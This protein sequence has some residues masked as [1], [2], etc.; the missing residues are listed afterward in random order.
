MAD[1]NQGG[2]QVKMTKK[3]KK[4]LLKI[5]EETAKNVMEKQG[6]HMP[7]IIF[8]T[9]EGTLEFMLLNIP[10]E[11]IKHMVLKGLRKKVQIEKIP[12]YFVIME[13][14][15]NLN[16][17][18]LPRNDPNRREAIFITEYNEDLTGKSVFLPFHWEEDKLVWE[19]RQVSDVVAPSP[20]NFYRE[21]VLEE[22]IEKYKRDNIDKFFLELPSELLDR[23]I[24]HVVE[25]A[26]RRGV[27]LTEDELRKML[28][29]AKESGKLRGILQKAYKKFQKDE[30]EAL[31]INVHMMII[32]GT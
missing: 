24:K 5:V 29:E 8:E 2:T 12:R 23:G 7:Q 13:A 22:T 30:I 31:K 9:R 28:T 21:D 18:I 4:E 11:G 3:Q 14:W 26:K 25:E 19:N 6:K 1:G 27:H 32:W 17:F 15:I 20:W 10:D 16:P